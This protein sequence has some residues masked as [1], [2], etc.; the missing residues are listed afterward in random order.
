MQ[1]N[2]L[3]RFMISVIVVS[4]CLWFLYPTAEYARLSPE[5]RERSVLK[6]KINTEIRKI[7]TDQP[8]FKAFSED[9]SALQALDHVSALV[10]AEKKKG[11]KADVSFSVELSGY[12]DKKDLAD[13]KSVHKNFKDSRE[14]VKKKAAD[15]EMKVAGLNKEVQF[16]KGDKVQGVLEKKLVRYRNLNELMKMNVDKFDN[17]NQARIPESFLVTRENKE[18][19]FV[20]S[21]SVDINSASYYLSE[22]VNETGK[23]FNLFVEDAGLT[24]TV[25]NLDVSAFVKNLKGVE[26]PRAVQQLNKIKTFFEWNRKRLNRVR[27]MDELLRTVVVTKLNS[28]FR[29]MYGNENFKRFAALGRLLLD[30]GH[31]GLE[32]HVLTRELKPNREALALIDKLLS[33]KKNIMTAEERR[34]MEA[35]KRFF[36]E[37]ITVLKEAEKNR[38]K[39]AFFDKKINLGLDLQGGM[40]IVLEAS[41]SKDDMKEFEEQLRRDYKNDPK[42]NDPDF[43]KTHVEEKRKEAF[44]QALNVIR[45]RV[46]KFGVAEAEVRRE[47]Y[48]RLS[49]HLPGIK[50]K[51]RARELIGRRGMLYL[52]IVDD[53][54][55]KKYISRDG[56]TL[57]VREDLLPGQYQ[58]I[59]IMST[60]RKTGKK[61]LR[62]GVIVDRQ[63]KLAGTEITN[64]YVSTGQ[65]GMP[66]VSFRLSSKGTKRFAEVTEKY[67]KKR[68]AIVIDDTASSAPS[69]RERIGGGQ[70]QISGLDSAEEARDIATILRSGALPVQVNIINEETI[71][72]TLGSDSI[73]KGAF[74]IVV[75]LGLVVLFMLL[76]YKMAGF[77]ADIALVFNIALILAALAP[78]GAALSLAGIAGIVLTVGIAVDANVIIFERIKEELKAG[79]T[80]RIA[81]D[82]GFEKAL[83][84]IIDANVTTLIAAFV[85]SQFGSGP[86]AGFAITLF[87]GILASLFTAL[88]LTKFILDLVVNKLW[89]KKLYI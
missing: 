63:P 10:F 34:Q 23:R 89:I 76:Y 61:N 3:L 73:R 47:G 72:A 46:D 37:N 81:I 29:D 83:S 20:M 68:M 74:A 28:K 17:Y 60:D 30:E 9:V 11:E 24:K 88:F 15:L 19:K 12:F 13:V 49:I 82:V 84:S 56:K 69:I 14:K 50:D 44:S 6:G 5:E 79:K 26:K 48:N 1:K 25:A 7:D 32:L 75:A 39:L 65:S 45:D 38:A 55:T 77:V 70:A 62:E 57:N 18:D 71:D 85:L 42:I 40:H 54:A 59:R 67:V 27:Q 87:I 66:E 86:I 36:N 33:E 80:N 31:K 21:L 78:L 53:E 2:F 43:L 41:M 58:Y 8:A 64:A 4:V 35:S 16:R 51:Q 52:K 22:Y